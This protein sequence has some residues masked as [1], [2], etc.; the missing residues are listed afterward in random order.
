M[1][2]AG[3]DTLE[4][5]HETQVLVEKKLRAPFQN[6]AAKGRPCG[7]ALDLIQKPPPLP[8]SLLF[9]SLSDVDALR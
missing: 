5:A 9:G 3:F 7:F 1:S 2:R 4:N 8:C 6:C